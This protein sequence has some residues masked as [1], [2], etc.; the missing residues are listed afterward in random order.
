[1]AI[2]IRNKKTGEIRQVEENELGNYIG[3]GQQQIG[4]GAQGINPDMASQMIQQYLMK[5]M[6]GAGST[7]GGRY[8]TQA[9]TLKDLFGMSE[10]AEQTNKKMSKVQGQEVLKMFEDQYFFNPRGP[11]SY[12]TSGVGG[13][14]S[15]FQEEVLA[16]ISADYNPELAAYMASLESSRPLFAKA[17]G[18]VGNMSASEQ[19]NAIKSIPKGRNSYEEAKLFFNMMR[20]RMGLPERDFDSEIATAGI[21]QTT[22]GNGEIIPIKIKGAKTTNTGGMEQ[23]AEEGEIVSE[24]GPKKIKKLPYKLLGGLL[25][26]LAGSVFLGPGTLVGGSIGAGIG[27]G[28]GSLLERASDKGTS[29]GNIYGGA[30][31]DIMSAGKAGIGTFLLGKL[32]SPF[33]TAHGG[34]DKLRSSGIAGKSASGQTIASGIKSGSSRAMAGTNAAG[35]SKATAGAQKYYSGSKDFPLESLLA[36]RRVLDETLRKASGDW[37]ASFLGQSA[38]VERDVLDKLIKGAGGKV[39]VADKMDTLLYKL[40]EILGNTVGAAGKAVPYAVGGAATGYMM[41]KAIGRE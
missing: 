18:D 3:G 35:L 25:G 16:K 19:E 27:T 1:M 6:A 4:G 41:N 9:Q 33:K 5:G 34:I 26:G 32:L 21:N 12:A 17:A 30:G 23:G 15:G 7:A 37:K 10:T 39:Q 28:L 14:A 29:P 20:K 11:L 38:K 8:L 2:T 13:R 31:E 24:G 22:R 40:Q 36:K